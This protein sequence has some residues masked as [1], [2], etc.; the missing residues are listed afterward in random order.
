MK[1]YFFTILILNYFFLT[2]NLFSQTE[3]QG[4]SKAAKDNF[5]LENYKDALEE[6]L[7]LLKNDSNNLLYN[8]RVGL[9]YLNLNIDKSKAI[10]Y[11]LKAS[12]D[13]K[14]ENFVWYELGR[15]YLIN[16]KPDEAIKYFKKYYNVTGGK[17]NYYVSS[18]R[19]IQMC[20]EAKSKISKPV[21]VTIENAGPEI[22]TAYAEYNPYIPGD[23]SFLVF[24]S[25][26]A[27]NTGGMTD[28]DGYPTSDIYISYQKYDK[29][30]KAKSVGPLINSEL[31]EE[32]VGISS[33]GTK[34]F[35]YCDNYT[36]MNEV[37]MS[38][39]KGKS[40]TKPVYL[41]E[42]I[43]SSKLE[44]SAAITPDKKYIVFSSDRNE[45][46]GGMDLYISKKLSNGAWGP[47]ENIGEPVNTI[48]DE[49]YPYFSADGKTLYFCSEGHNSMGGYDIFKSTWNEKD[50]S[51]SKPENL[52]YPI[53]TTDDD[54]TISFSSTGRHAYIASSRPGGYGGLDIYKIIFNDIDPAYTILSGT[55]L[56]NDSMNIYKA[57]ALSDTLQKDSLIQLTDN[58]LAVK[59]NDTLVKNN[60]TTK[61][62][63]VDISVIDKSTQKVFGK[64]HPNVLNGKF[65][66]ILPPGDY[67]INV[68]AEG[69]EKYSED[70]SV[71]DRNSNTE[72][73]KDIMLP[74]IVKEPE[75]APVNEQ[76]N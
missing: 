47:A 76:K 42:N 65:L 12:A 46:A 36:A 22:N 41:G 7:N 72:I 64:Y 67:K 18:Q 73:F 56:N 19:M 9:C 51:W 49:D 25:K 29:W 11:L 10:P 27:G 35:I 75:I 20:E 37:L 43:N 71:S 28:F 54:M 3:N 1:K 50:D 62:I 23:E 31:V 44:T 45:E 57:L 55:L 17:E 59:N 60:N 4:N 74:A 8:M 16:Y 69:Y 24:T 39:K 21:N 58:D 33:D 38:E 40:F 15:A 26:R 5:S 32:S 53:N 52:G 61:K 30:T 13:P 2:M 48:Y 66:I 14:V 70:I 6:Y 34:L 63:P 68:I